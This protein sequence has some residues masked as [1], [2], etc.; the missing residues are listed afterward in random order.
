MKHEREDTVAFKTHLGWVLSCPMFESQQRTIKSSVFLNSA[1]VL[2]LDT[3][4]VEDNFRLKQELSKFWDIKSMGVVPESEDMV[5]EQFE[6]K[7]QM[8]DARYQVSLP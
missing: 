7:V 2:R 8:K 6:N 3:E 4:Q 5:Y 1:Y